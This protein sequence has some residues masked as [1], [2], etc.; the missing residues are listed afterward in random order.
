MRKD[1]RYESYAHR[2]HTYLQR[3]QYAEQLEHLYRLFSPDQVLVMRSESMF[4]DPR[5]DLQRV[6]KHLG[7]ASVELDGRDHL[8]ATHAPLDIPPALHERLT[9]YYRPWNERLAQ[10]PGVTFTWN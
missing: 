7:L 8:K 10:L 6:W 3:G 5:G 2:H 1:P 4:T 9:E